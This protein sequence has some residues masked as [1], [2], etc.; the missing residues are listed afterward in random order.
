MTIGNWIAIASILL[1]Q[2]VGLITSYVYIRIKISELDTKY[3]NLNLELQEHKSHNI[4][5]RAETLASIKELSV[6][7][8]NLIKYLMQKNDNK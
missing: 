1:V 5:D 2:I 6:K 3:K 8:D 7:I 4:A